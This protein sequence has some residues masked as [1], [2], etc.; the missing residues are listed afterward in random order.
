MRLAL[1]AVLA[2]GL[3]LAACAPYGVAGY[4]YPSD[5]AYTTQGYGYSPYGGQG[6]YAPPTVYA[7]QAYGYSQPLYAQPYGY[8]RGYERNNVY[9]AP[10]RVYHGNNSLY[11]AQA[12]PP[13][14]SVQ[15][16]QVNA[17]HETKSFERAL[18]F[19]PN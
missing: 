14:R 5:G 6:Y 13:E 16:A 8:Q 15:P 18:G 4:G 1:A 10:E 3:A 2:G 12:R 11:R 17:S 7:P 9:R 19:V